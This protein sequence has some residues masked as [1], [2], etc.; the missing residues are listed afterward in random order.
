MWKDIRD[1]E[2]GK[3]RPNSFANRVKSDRV[4]SL[5]LSNHKDIVSPHRGSVNSLQ[6]DLTEGRYLLSGASDA[7]AAVFDIQRASHSEGLIAKYQCLFAV[8]KQHEHGHKYAISSAI[9]YPIDTGLFVTGSYDH[10]INVWDTNTTQV[11][12]NFKLPGKVYRTAMSSLATSH[13]LIAAGTE[14]VQVRLC[15]ISSG[16][17][18]HTLSGHR[19]GVMSVEWSASSE[20]VLITGGCDGAIRFW[21]IRRAGCFRVLDQS[22]SQLGRRPPI[23]GWTANKLSTSK[24]HLAS[25]SSNMKS[26]ILHKKLSNGNATK[27][28]STTGKLPAKGSTR[29]R[30]HPGLLSSQ[31]RAVSHYGA[32]TGLKV[33]GDGMYLLSAGSDSRLKLW[34][35]ESGCNT[36]VNYE[37]VRLHTNK[38]LQLAT[39][40][41]SALVFA[42]C[43][44]N[45][46]AFDMWTGKASLTLSGH[47]EAVNCC[48]YSFQDQELY[49]GGNDRQI[50]VWSPSRDSTELW[51]RRIGNPVQTKITGATD[52]PLPQGR[53]VSTLM[54]S[55]KLCPPCT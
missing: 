36:L 26:R 23:S 39:S 15:D 7:S 4:S 50:L 31:D 14:D 47:Y 37:T 9:W 35:V 41:D 46:K 29:Q 1:R 30:L 43:M 28:S 5:Q 32:V 22:Q 55:I 38:P 12:V 18:S 24:S 17:F 25:Q 54:P 2:A 3:L 6:V 53:S 8:D 11:V 48:L 52:C 10:H 45:I 20:W 21:D 44:A 13:M 27:P 16:A 49:T 40:Q 33:T 34:D 42:P 51:T 19:D